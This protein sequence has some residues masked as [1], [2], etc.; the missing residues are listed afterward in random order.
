MCIQSC[1]TQRT[2]PLQEYDSSCPEPNRNT[3]YLSYLDSVKYFRPEAR[4]ALNDSALRSMVYHE[5]LLGYMDHAKR[6]GMNALYIWSCPPL[7]VRPRAHLPSLCC[8]SCVSFSDKVGP[9]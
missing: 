9:L 6:L 4:T 2:L 1:S 3:C 8:A 5:V 7:A